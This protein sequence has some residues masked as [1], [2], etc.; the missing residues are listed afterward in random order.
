MLGSL[1]TEQAWSVWHSEG[2]LA[3][4]EIP[5]IVCDCAAGKIDGDVPALAVLHTMIALN[6]ARSGSGAYVLIVFVF[7]FG[8]GCFRPLQLNSIGCLKPTEA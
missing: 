1:I 2:S 7:I 3:K 6:K 4:A 8:F 5:Y